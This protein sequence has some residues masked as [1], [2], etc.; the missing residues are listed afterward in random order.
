M[1]GWQE[2]GGGDPESSPHQIPHSHPPSLPQVTKGA[3]YML[4][5]AGCVS[6]ESTNGKA[7][8]ASSFVHLLKSRKEDL[9]SFAL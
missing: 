2:I 5:C 1:G 7:K 3:P 8:L 9:A 6:R 4:W